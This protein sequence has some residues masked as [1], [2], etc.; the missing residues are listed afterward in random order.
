MKIKETD[1]FSNTS[2][3]EVQKQNEQKIGDKKSHSQRAL[4]LE[5]LADIQLPKSTEVIV[6]V[7]K[8]L[9]SSIGLTYNV[10]GMMNSGS[11][12]RKAKAAL[13]NC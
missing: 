10:G 3:N 11:T 6:D 8:L 12:R 4:E 5:K 9:P 13:I 2:K 1:L 7:Q